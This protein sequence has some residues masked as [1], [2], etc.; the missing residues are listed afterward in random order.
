MPLPTSPPKITAAVLSAL[1]KWIFIGIGR[2]EEGRGRRR[3]EE[4]GRR[5]EEGDA[6]KIAN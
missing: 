2:K 5:E 1:R 4:G 6:P 3:E